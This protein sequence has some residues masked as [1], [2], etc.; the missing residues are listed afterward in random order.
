VRGNLSKNR[1]HRGN[2]TLCTLFFETYYK[3]DMKKTRYLIAVSNYFIII[4]QMF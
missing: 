1:V 3:N 2:Y 4:A